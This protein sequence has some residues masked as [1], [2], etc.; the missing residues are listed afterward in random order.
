MMGLF[1]LLIVEF[2][3]W[4]DFGT[5]IWEIII[6]LKVLAQTVGSVVDNQL[7]EA[8]LSAPITTSMGLI[9]GMVTLSADDFMDFL[10][11]YIVEFGFLIMERMYIDPGQGAFFD[12]LDEFLGDLAERVARRL[13][14]FISGR[15]L[16]SK[17]EGEEKEQSDRDK[18]I[19]GM[20]GDGAETVEP[21]LDSFGSYC[22]DTMSLLYTPVNIILLMMFRNETGIPEIYGIKEQDMLYYLM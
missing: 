6:L 19:A 8:L 21:I 1:L 13:P 11:S 18:E 10:Y 17:E 9:Q 16:K 12:W 22:C 5:Y 7:N 3:F 20:I 2:S 15:F 4:G 14:K